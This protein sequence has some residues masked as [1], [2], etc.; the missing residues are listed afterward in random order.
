MCAAS[1]ALSPKA[2]LAI[3]SS[4]SQQGGYWG[5][6]RPHRH[7]WLMR[8]S[9]E[10]MREDTWHFEVEVLMSEREEAVRP[11]IEFSAVNLSPEKDLQPTSTGGPRAC[12]RRRGKVSDGGSS[13]QRDTAKSGGLSLDMRIPVMPPDSSGHTDFGTKELPKGDAV[14]YP[15]RGRA[16]LSGYCPRAFLFLSVP[17]RDTLDISNYDTNKT[18]LDEAPFGHADDDN[19]PGSEPPPH[20]RNIHYEPPTVSGG[21]RKAELSSL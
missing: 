9:K 12:Y 11:Q 7:N 18:R 17:F 3:G 4:S 14:K 16:A 21:R 6:P 20:D 13:P 10:W 19:G 5:V 8:T 2:L 15:H 1:S